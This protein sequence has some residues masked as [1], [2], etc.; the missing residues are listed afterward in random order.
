MGIELAL[1]VLHG[2]RVIKLLRNPVQFENEWGA[3]SE[4]DA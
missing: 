2:C 4:F 3:Q 1:N